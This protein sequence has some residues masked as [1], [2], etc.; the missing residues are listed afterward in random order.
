MKYS[1]KVR[2]PF[3]FFCTIFFGSTTLYP[4]IDGIRKK[5]TEKRKTKY[6]LFRSAVRATGRAIWKNKGK[7]LVGTGALVVGAFIIWPSDEEMKKRTIN[8]GLKA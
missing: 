2:L 3:V 6:E 4:F 7:M 1:L 8:N 5:L